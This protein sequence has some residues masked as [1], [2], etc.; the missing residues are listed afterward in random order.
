[1]KRRTAQAIKPDNHDRTIILERGDIDK[2]IDK[3]LKELNIK[4][5]RADIKITEYTT[6]YLFFFRKKYHRIEVATKGEKEF[7][8]DAINKFMDSL[9][10]KYRSVTYSRKKGVIILTINS[11]DSKNRLVGRQGRT[12]QAIEYMLNKIALSNGMKVKI[13]VSIKP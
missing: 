10:I 9:S 1:M 3:A 5:P 7:L 4:R 12:I 8:L 2:A 13:I 11:P 6:P